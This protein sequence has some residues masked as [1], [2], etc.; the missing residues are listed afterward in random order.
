MLLPAPAARAA[1]REVKP[2]P[3]A[4]AQAL[5]KAAPG[6]TLVLSPGLY[7]GPLALSKP[8]M[9]DA[10]PG[11]VVEGDGSGSVLH[12]TARNVAVRGLTIRKSG[13]RPTEYDAGILVEQGADGFVAEN[14]TLEENLFGIVLHGANGSRVRANRIHGRTDPYET[15]RGNAI[16]LWNVKDTEIVGN[17]LGGGRDGIFVDVSHGNLIQGN[18]MEGVRFAV[19]YMN[20][21]RGR[22]FDNVSVGNK[23]GFALMYSNQLDIERNLSEDDAEHGLMLHSAHFSKLIDNTIRRG[24]G[25]KCLFVYASSNAL[26]RGNRVEGCQI[27]L[28]FTGGSEKGLISGN[29]FVNNRTQVKYT[30]TIVYE[31]SEGGRGNYWSDNTAFDLDGDGLADTAYRPNTVMDRVVWRYPLA[32]LLMSSPLMEALRFAQSQFP[33]LM[34]GGVVDSHPLMAPPA[35]VNRE[36]PVS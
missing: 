3:A 25:D 24:K 9:L 1:T 30:G 16:H 11:A 36:R 35:A 14:N 5:A 13:S 28:H 10:R 31:W 4:L 15:E 7:R 22:V 27:G 33:A 19:H 12:V 34:P 32:K 29:A 26:I 2:G 23:L 17:T 20:S 8:V 18:R 21:N 6:D